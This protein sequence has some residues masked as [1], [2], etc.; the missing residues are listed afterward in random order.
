MITIEEVGLKEIQEKLGNLSHR[1]P[2]VIQSASNRTATATRN[3]L[4]KHLKETYTINDK[5]SELKKKLLIRRASNK[6]VLGA[7]I[8][9]K[10]ERIGLDHFKVIPGNPPQ[11]QVVRGGK[12]HTLLHAFVMQNVGAGRYLNDKAGKNE[13]LGRVGGS[14]SRTHLNG[15]I[16]SRMKGRGR[17]PIRRRFTISLPE[18]LGAVT[19]KYHTED[20]DQFMADKFASFI[21]ERIAKDLE[22]HARY[23]IDISHLMP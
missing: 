7:E 20:I 13:R 15:M 19:N 11:V 5:V 6:N 1:L 4:I 18:M 21:D 14:Y 12:A 17:L 2:S 8:R 3:E 10:S 16:F 23:E 9:M 22:K